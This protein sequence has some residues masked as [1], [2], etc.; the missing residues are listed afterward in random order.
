MDLINER[1]QIFRDILTSLVSFVQE[2]EEIKKDFDEYINTIIG[3]SRVTD[4]ILDDYAA[5]CIN[6]VFERKLGTPLRSIARLY[7]E[8]TKGLDAQT[9]KFIEALDNVT[10]FI[11]RVKRVLKTGFEL[12]NIINEKEY[13]VI[14]LI[15]MLELK[16]IGIGNYIVAR[17]VQFDG[18][19][20]ILDINGVLP[21][22]QKAEAYRYAVAKIVESPELVYKDSPEKLEEIEKEVELVNEK[23]V[24]YFGKKVVL[25]TSEL[26]DGLIGAF[27]DYIEEEDD[28]EELEKVDIDY[29]QFIE[30]PKTYQFFEIEEFNNSYDNFLENSLG[31]FSAHEE[32]YDVALVCDDESG[33]MA[34]PFWGTFNKIFEVKDYTT[35]PN[36]DTCIKYF[37]ENDRFSANLI[38]MVASEHKNFMEIVNSVYAKNYTLDELLNVYKRRYLQ[39]KIISSTTVLYRS[40]VFEEMLDII[41]EEEDK[42]VFDR[43]IGRNEPCPC[44]SGKK[45][46]KCCGANL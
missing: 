36:Y 3:D 39:N 23:F 16:S 32:V 18:D 15:K 20:Y 21:E 27:N 5:D 26:V 4:I 11:Y 44:G 1:K 30:E 29:H 8:K 34:V 10:N 35:I 25:T 42:P 37:V 14:S 9:K 45:F 46:K 17:I 19:Y 7:I 6:Y 43:K 12:S 13:N 40:K 22:Y 28:D 33:M 24:E 31:G 41:A 38:R 2:D